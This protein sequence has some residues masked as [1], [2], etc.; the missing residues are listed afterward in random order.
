M[1]GYQA[2][3]WGEAA[4]LQ[5]DGAL[6]GAQRARVFEERKLPEPVVLGVFGSKTV[7]PPSEY[8]FP[9]VDSSGAEGAGSTGV[10]SAF[11]EVRRLHFMLQKKTEVRE[12]L[13]V[14]AGRVRNACG[15]LRAQ[16]QAQALE[17]R[18]TLAK[19]PSFKA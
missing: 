18:G 9:G 13:K 5:C 15:E 10:C 2:V 11:E 8:A 14:K 3:P 1:L 16:V 12:Y 7:V 17:E 19:V 6:N 4:L